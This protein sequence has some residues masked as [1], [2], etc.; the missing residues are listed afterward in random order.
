M[1]SPARRSGA[2]QQDDPYAAAA[3]G[4]DLFAAPYRAAQA[5][6]L[7]ALAV[8]VD[9]ANGPLLDIGAGSGWA[10]G[11]LLTRLT[12]LRIVALEPSA[13]LRAVCLGRIADHA[14]WAPRITVRPEDF[15][16]ATLPDRICGAVLLGVIGHFDSGERRAV[17]A[18][19]AA[20]TV[21]GAPVLVDLPTPERPRRIEPYEIDGAAVGELSYRMI[22]ES[23]PLD[24]EAMIWRMTYLCLDG[25]RVLTETMVEHVYRHPAPSVFAREAREAGFTAEHPTGTE[26]WTLRRR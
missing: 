25:E 23:R 6:A 13:A 24:T 8:S 18:E 2:G 20:R 10:A 3:C 19:L 14:D 7:D 15:F 12:T 21:A 9:P 1:T 16:S 5:A 11:H 17:L 4:V 22:A 26:H